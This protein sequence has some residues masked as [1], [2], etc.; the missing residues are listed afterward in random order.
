MQTLNEM[1]ASAIPRPL[2]V[3]VWA[4]LIRMSW[5]IAVALVAGALLGAT[6]QRSA[7]PTYEARSL[8]VV[9]DAQLPTAS[10]GDLAQAAFGTDTVLQPV[11]DQLHLNATPQSLLSNHQLEARAVALTGAMA[12][13]GHASDPTV[14]RDLANLAAQSFVAAA[15]ERGLGTFVQ[16]GSGNNPV[17]VAGSTLSRSVGLAGGLGALLGIV[18]LIAVFAIRQPVLSRK[19]AEALFTAD[20]SFLV[21]TRSSLRIPRRRISP[22]DIRPRGLV[23]AVWRAVGPRDEP[24]VVVVVKAER[25]RRN[26]AAVALLN[27]LVAGGEVTV[28]DSNLQVLPLALSATRVVIALVPSGVGARWIRDLDEEVLVAPQPL[29]R[30]LLFLS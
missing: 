8:V 23:P 7:K 9:S 30:I 22:S 18:L 5:V 2:R 4:W 19:E 25:G 27:A 10:V 21:E 11:I 26:P 29:R 6:F 17:A 15:N 14:A 20:A 16:F 24:P 12:I 1:E 13:I 28:L 3:P